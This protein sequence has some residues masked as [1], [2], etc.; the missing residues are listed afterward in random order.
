MGDLHKVSVD[1]ASRG[2]V[3]AN[4]HEPRSIFPLGH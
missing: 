3:Q 4:P 1:G 2:S